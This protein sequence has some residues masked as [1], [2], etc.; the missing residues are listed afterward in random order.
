MF[1]RLTP[2]APQLKEEQM[3]VNSS[4]SSRVGRQ[5]RAQSKRATPST[6]HNSKADALANDTFQSQGPGVG[7]R[8]GGAL[9]AGVLGGTMAAGGIVLG[10]V[11]SLANGSAPSN[12]MDSL[13]NGTW[14][15]LGGLALV[16]AT[17]ALMGC[18]GYNTEETWSSRVPGSFEAMKKRERANLIDGLMFGATTGATLAAGAVFG[19]KGVAGAAAL[20]AA[21]GAVN[22]YIPGPEDS[23]LYRG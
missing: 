22:G 11:M 18:V 21:V 1:Y 13:V 17:T 6:K 8:I 10:T 7:P 5:P 3:N 2:L 23:I 16:G 9:Y 19:L 14:P 15:V 20:T 4:N 12:P